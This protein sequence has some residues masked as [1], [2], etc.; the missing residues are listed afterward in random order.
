MNS[1]EWANARRFAY[2]LPVLHGVLLVVFCVKDLQGIVEEI[3]IV[4]F[5]L[6]ILASPVLMNVDVSV[7]VIVL[8]YLVCGSALWYFVGKALDRLFRMN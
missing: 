2:G 8:Y 6:T 1:R 3:G 4:D 5:P 7:L